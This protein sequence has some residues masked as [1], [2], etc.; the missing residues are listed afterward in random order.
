ML[1][2]RA[3]EAHP[4]PLPFGQLS[5]GKGAGR[6]A[7][8]GP[9][10]GPGAGRGRAPARGQRGFHRSRLEPGWWWDTVSSTDS[11]IQHCSTSA[12]N[13][14]DLRRAAADEQ[15]SRQPEDR[16]P[17][18]TP[19]RPRPQGPWPPPPAGHKAAYSPCPGIREW[20][21]QPQPARP[22]PR[23]PR[24]LT[25]SPAKL[26]KC[27][28]GMEVVPTAQPITSRRSP[29]RPP[30]PSRRSR[31]QAAATGYSPGRP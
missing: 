7:A 31:S 26:L 19:P 2:E 10:A 9:C 20:R 16:P 23:P 4:H 5:D 18:P 29:R 12:T 21:W 22:P 13:Q 17:P 6:V 14:Y 24:V 30:W 8:G 11:V 28:Q 1:A 15:W 27:E 3:A 25:M